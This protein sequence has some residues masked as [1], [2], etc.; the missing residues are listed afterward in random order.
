MLELGP[1]TGQ[2]TE[3][4]LDTGCDYHAVEIGDNF[5]DL[6]QKKYGARE[7]FHLIHDDFITHDFGDKKFDLIYS[8]A[9]IQWIPEEIAFSK[10]FDLLNPGGTLA[11]MLTRGDYKTPNEPLY[12]EIQKVYSAY[13]KPATPYTHGGFG[14]TNAS[15]YGYG[16]VEKR[17]FFGQRVKHGSVVN[18][19]LFHEDDGESVRALE[20]TMTAPMT[21]A[22]CINA[23][24][25]AAYDLR[26]AMDVAAFASSLS[27]KERTG[28]D[29]EEV[30]EHDQFIAD[31][32]AELTALGIL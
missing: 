17:E 22:K 27:R 13:Y 26:D 18:V 24:E 25:M 12:N 2:A 30:I 19:Y 15:S 23:A 7:N 4:I 5:C 28:E 9:T 6:L 8:A 10:T 32:K 20:V 31:V 11:M 21:R 14:Y 3:P 29:V 16:A 1:G